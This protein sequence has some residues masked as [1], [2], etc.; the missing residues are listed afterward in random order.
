MNLTNKRDAF[1][2]DMLSLIPPKFLTSSSVGIVS[3][4]SKDTH[5]VSHNSSEQNDEQLSNPTAAA[6]LGESNVEKHTTVSVLVRGDISSRIFSTWAHQLPRRCKIPES[7]ILNY[8]DQLSLS[9]VDNGSNIV[10]LPT[11]CDP[12]AAFSFLISAVE[13]E[14]N[15]KKRIMRKLLTDSSANSPLLT[16]PKYIVDSIIAGHFL[17]PRDPKYQHNL[18]KELLCTSV[19]AGSAED[20][21]DKGPQ[22]YEQPVVPSNNVSIEPLS[23]PLPNPEVEIAQRQQRRNEGYLCARPPPN[24][25]LPARATGNGNAAMIK[26]LE[27]L[28][29]VYAMQGDE[30][31]TLGYKKA[32]VQ[33]KKMPT[34]TSVEQLS[35]VKGIGKRLREKIGEILESGALKKLKFLQDDPKTQGIIIYFVFLCMAYIIKIFFLSELL[36]VKLCCRYQKCGE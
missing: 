24:P 17:N 33:L 27:E 34:I 31:R 16:N 30:W 14:E 11:N 6:G 7:S 13:I 2:K 15:E 3:R 32:L 22:G 4:K 29:G 8:F 5:F 20:L 28:K 18:Q 35:G 25:S 23:M 19:T 36:F 26:M 21:S 9:A 1:V 12:A 10:V